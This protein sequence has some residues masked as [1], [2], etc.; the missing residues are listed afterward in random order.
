MEYIDYLNLNFRD[1]YYFEYFPRYEYYY[2]I[3]SEFLISDILLNFQFS[4]YNYPINLI[5]LNLENIIL[6]FLGFYYYQDKDFL[7]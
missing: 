7:N 3:N 6:L 4:W 2:K 5:L 1:K